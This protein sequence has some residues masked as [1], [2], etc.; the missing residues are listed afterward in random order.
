MIVH[1]VPANTGV[2]IDTPHMSVSADFPQVSVI[3]RPTQVDVVINDVGIS[4]NPGMPIAKEYVGSDPYTDTYIAT[5][6]TEAQTFSTKNLR[7]TDDF[8]VNPIPSNYGLITWNGSTLTV[9]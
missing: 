7:M 4:V 6:S 5:P 1:A 8:V 2:N 9:S 3:N